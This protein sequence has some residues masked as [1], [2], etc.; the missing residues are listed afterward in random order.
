MLLAEDGNPYDPNAVSVWIDGLMVGY[1]PRDQA[2]TL[3]PG[4]LAAQERKGKPIALEGVVAGGG[5]RDDGPGRLGVFLRYDPEDFGISAPPGAKYA[6]AW[7]RLDRAPADFGTWPAPASRPAPPGQRGIDGAMRTG[8]AEAWLTDVEDD[9]YDLS[10]YNDLPEADRPAITKLRRLLATDRSPIDRHF[11]FAELEARLYRSRDLY[12]SALAEYDEACIQ[13]D[14]EMEGICRAFMA[15]WGKIPLLET[16]RQMA[17]RQ[18]KNK[19]WAACRWWAERGLTLYGHGA[20]R[21]EAVEDL[22]KRRNR[23][24]AKLETSAAPMRR[25]SPGHTPQVTASA[26]PPLPTPSQIPPNSVVEVL[27]SN[28][29]HPSN[30]CDPAGA[31]RCSARNAVPQQTRKTSGS[32]GT[33]RAGRPARARKESN[34]ADPRLGGGGMRRAGIPECL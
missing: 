6:D 33:R 30:E 23:A 18:A 24:I 11:Q 12:E 3:R 29:A 2:R 8:L 32:G 20:A 25:V 26:A 5:M 31:S 21:E 1:L 7:P 27:V 10:W 19:D 13:H 17:I 4:L 22:T 15:K 34:P 9:S 28:A 14:A 16:Y